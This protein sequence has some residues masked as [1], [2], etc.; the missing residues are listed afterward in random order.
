MKRIL[1]ALSFFLILGS[2]C[3]RKVVVESNLNADQAIF[4][5]QP[6][7]VSAEVLSHLCIVDVRSY[8]FD[9]KLHQGQ[10]VIHKELAPDIR[11]IFDVILKEHFPVESV[12]PVS[13]PAIVAKGPYGLSPD[14]NNTSGYVWRPI[15]GAQSLSMH[16]LGM[17]VDINPRLNPYRKGEVVLPPGATYEVSIP[18]TL[19]PNSRVVMAFKERGWEWGGDWTGGKVDYMHFQKIPPGWEEFRR[20]NR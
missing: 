17:A 5:N 16:A 15:V 10:I 19:T 7:D 4:Q 2:G 1:I 3:A 14:T 20:T 8:G 11:D 12:L 6:P 13:H 18:G 9:G